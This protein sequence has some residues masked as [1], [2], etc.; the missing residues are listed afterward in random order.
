MP[1][2]EM[3]VIGWEIFSKW[4]CP[5]TCWS[6]YIPLRAT[7]PQRCLFFNCR[8]VILDW[9]LPNGVCCIIIKFILACVCQ[10]SLLQ[11]ILGKLEAKPTKMPE[12]WFTRWLWMSTGGSVVYALWAGLTSAVLCRCCRSP[13]HDDQL[14]NVEKG[15]GP[16]SAD[17]P[18][19]VTSVVASFDAWLF[20]DSKVLWAVLISEIFNHVN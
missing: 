5:D 15:L 17:K 20:A 14:N 3:P 7:T 10:S 9:C 6:I 12:R 16:I 1:D 19:S 13:A 4:A 18:T 11:L 8:H 2:R